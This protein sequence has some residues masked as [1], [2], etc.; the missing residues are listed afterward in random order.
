M[1]TTWYPDIELWFKKYGFDDEVMMALFN[2]FLINLHYTKNYIQTVADAWA[3]K[4][5]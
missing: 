2:H 5:Y 1:P 4:F 3:K